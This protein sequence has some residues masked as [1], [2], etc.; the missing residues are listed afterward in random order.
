[1]NGDPWYK[2]VGYDNLSIEIKTS[3]KCL[4]QENEEAFYEFDIDELYVSLI[5]CGFSDLTMQELEE[6]LGELYNE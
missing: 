1:M 5:E 3:K 6:T 4:C 2:N